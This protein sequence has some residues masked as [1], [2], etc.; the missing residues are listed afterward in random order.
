MLPLEGVKV[1][2]LTRVLSG[3]YSTMI[4]GDF[5]AEIIKVETPVTGDD[6][7]GFGPYV[8]GE[9]A[10]YMSINRNKKSITIDTRNPKGCDLVK[11]MIAK[12][13]VV[14][15]NFKPGTMEKLGMGYEDLKKI[16]PEIIYVA[17]SGFG[18]NGPYSKRPAYDA[19]VQAAG[20]IMSITGPGEGQYT[21][22]GASVGDITAGLF[23][24]LGT[25]LAIIDKQKT[26]KGQKVDVAMLDCQVAILENAIARYCVSG[27]V[28]QPKGNR[29]ASLTP[30]EDFV[31][32]DGDK[33][34]IAVGN[35]GLWKKFLTVAN[36]MDLFDDP[37]F[38]Q[39]KD[40]TANYEIIKPILDEI[41]LTKTAQ[42][43][44][45]EL[46]AA[47][48]PVTFVN[49]IDKLVKNEQVLARDMILEIDQPKVGTFKA[50]NTP[51]KMSRT[52]GGLRTPAPLLGANTDE[53]LKDFLGKTDEE[54]QELRDNKIL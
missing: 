31:C 6:S 36:R 8:N 49:T 54:I 24:A 1:V 22:V 2:D 12:A 37:R 3:P 25:L 23:T 18:H 14:V 50:A 40:R 43:W 4:L 38:A 34:M 32:K 30:F 47:S 27:E 11:E 26:G 35:N 51:I 33:V 44:Y 7:R 29:H 16:N 13:D 52:Q 20:G 17:C 42:E 39:N 41:F 48:V 19:I 21:R 28:P 53:V 46:V 5:G 15:E 9:S 45:D 10:Y